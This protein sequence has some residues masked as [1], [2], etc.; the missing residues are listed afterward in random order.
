VWLPLAETHSGLHESDT[1]IDMYIC[2]LQRALHYGHVMLGD[3]SCLGF[4]EKG[5]EK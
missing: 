5:Y 3:H 2:H 4:K 1:H